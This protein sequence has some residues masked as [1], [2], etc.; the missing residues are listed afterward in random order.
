MTLPPKLTIEQL[1]KLL[2]DFTEFAEIGEGGFK[3][4]FKAMKNGLPEVIKVIN[5]PRTES[6]DEQRFHKESIG[7]VQREVKILN[8]C[9]TPFLVKPASL[10]LQDREVNGSFYAIYSEEFL[11]GSDLWKLIREKGQLPS[12]A[13]AKLL[14]LCLLRAIQELWSKRYVHRD[15]KPQNVI[16]LADP[17][18]PF[19]LID[20]GIAF[21]L[22]E[23]GLTVQGIPC[24][25]RYLAPEMTNP[26][27][28]DSLDFRSDLYTSALTVF[29][30]STGQHPVA[31]DSDDVMMTLTRVVNDPAK[32]L[33]SLRSDFSPEFCSLIDQ[34]LKKK[35]MLRPANLGK[36]ISVL[37]S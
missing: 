15:I 4:V 34:L 26:A 27:F 8:E 2:P 35:P 7:R 13:E 17:N 31:K 10:P 20:L 23:T 6:E 11:N 29:E 28:R 24:T 18:R 19:V 5:I 14:L 16:K 36:L 9:G 21:G 37:E 3:T 1:A 25:A 12:E 22:L 32:P 30:Y 33:G